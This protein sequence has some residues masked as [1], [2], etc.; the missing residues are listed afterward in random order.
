M[1]PADEVMATL[2]KYLG[3]D[4]LPSMDAFLEVVGQPFNPEDVIGPVLRDY[5]VPDPVLPGSSLKFVV[6]K[7]G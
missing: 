4:L 2:S 6:H 5:S 3:P 1:A 7:V